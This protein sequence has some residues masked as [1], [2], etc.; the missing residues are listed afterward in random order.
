[1]T[2]RAPKDF[3]A[4]LLFIAFAAVALYAARNYSLGG[5]GRM[6]PGYFPVLLGGLLALIGAVLV[7]RSFFAPGEPV[8][9][10]QFLPLA[11]IVVSVVLFGVLLQHFGLVIA[12]VAVTVVS[13]FATRESKPLEVA[14]LTAVLVVFSIGIFVQGLKLQ[15]PIWP[16]F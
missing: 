9:R 4:G 7:G 13:A 1:M 14:A 3:W 16:Q 11:I 15:L 6:G 5:A 2:I 10:T 12:L 8:T